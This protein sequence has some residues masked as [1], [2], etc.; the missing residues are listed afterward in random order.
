MKYIDFENTWRG[1]Y[2]TVL[3]PGK[4]C[5]DLV[6]KWARDLGVP[7]YPGHPS[8]FPYLYAYQIY[9][10]FGSFQ[11]MYFDRIYNSV[12]AIPKEGDILVWGSYYNGGPG[13]TAVCKSGVQANLQAFS[14]NDPTGS[15]CIVKTYNYNNIL[16]WLRPKAYNTVP[17]LTDAQIVKAHKDIVNTGMSDTDYRNKSR[18]L[19]NV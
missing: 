19:L 6:V 4:Q 1:K 5:F 16:G 13:H 17:P 15:V 8:M 18:T 3:N 14:Q 11:A 10:N 12:T 9:T 2:L 7:N